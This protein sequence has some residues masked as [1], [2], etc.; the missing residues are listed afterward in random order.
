MVLLEKWRYVIS[1]M[2][3]IDLL[4]ILPSYRPLRVLRFF[5]L[6]RVFKLF[7]Y[8]RND[9]EFSR[10]LLEKR[11]ELYTLLILVSFVTF[12]SATAIYI[13]EATDDKSQINTFFD[14]IY[15]ALITLSTVGYGD[16][17]PQSTAGRVVTLV[18]IM[19]GIGVIA[20]VTSIVVSA[21]SEKMQELRMRQVFYAVEKNRDWIVVCGFGRV[22]ESVAE[23]L[24]G[25]GSRFIVIDKDEERVELAK[26][27]GYLAIR[28]DAG[29][30]ELLENIGIR[31]RVASVLC[32]TDDDV[33]NVYITLTARA[34]NPQATIISRTSTL[35]AEKK[36][37]L[38]GASHVV[39]PYEVVGLMAAEFIGQPV[40]TRA[41]NS[42]L[43]GEH[44]MRLEV[45][46]ISA[47]SYLAE[48]PLSAADFTGARLILFGVIAPQGQERHS[49]RR[50]FEL[51]TCRFYFHPAADF[52]VLA[53]DLLVVFGRAISI[54]HFRDQLEKSAL[55]QR[56]RTTQRNNRDAFH[57]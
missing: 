30:T 46:Q 34:L 32:V 39:T 31:E 1:P 10:V 14:A 19:S 18:L 7:R 22:G 54:N 52:V 33:T 9:N 48:S 5:L 51:Q 15:W 24:A 8:T 25:A 27:R 37:Y 17:T 55:Q 3:V 16:I 40:A 13:F 49:Q 26:E 4:A 56:R 42:I 44:N 20:F 36:L 6:F 29:Q 35:Q 28:G 45:I 2:A 21:F 43:S 38:A 47:G 57:P 53:N 11:F 12:A 50:H 23:R 41:I